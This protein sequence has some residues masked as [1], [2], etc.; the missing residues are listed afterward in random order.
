MRKIDGMN[1]RVADAASILILIIV[2]ITVYEVV[3]RYFFDRP[4]I[5]VNETG[6]MLFSLVF[7]FGAAYTLQLGRHVGVD[8][9]T[10]TL[11][12]GKRRYVDLIMYFFFFAFVLLFIWKTGEWGWDSII[13]RER[14]HSVWEPYVF[15]L[16]ASVPVAGVLLFLQGIVNFI[17]ILKEDEVEGEVK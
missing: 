17:R 10:R 12:A 5:W 16:I 9:I 8:V 14:I 3:M 4:T 13:E 15:P 6:Q 1:K 2:G 7:L 11:S